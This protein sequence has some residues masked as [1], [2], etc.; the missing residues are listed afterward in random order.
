MA[1]DWDF[2]LLKMLPFLHEIKKEENIKTIRIFVAEACLNID[3]RLKI[4]N[5]KGAGYIV[6]ENA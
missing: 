3:I 1:E 4:T 6:S 2:F 5:G